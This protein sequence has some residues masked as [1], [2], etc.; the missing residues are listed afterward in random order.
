[1][2][3][4]FFRFFANI[5]DGL[6]LNCSTE[7]VRTVFTQT[8]VMPTYLVAFI[9]SDFNCTQGNPIDTDVPHSVCSTKESAEERALAVEY[10]PRLMQALENMVGLKFKDQGLGKMHQVAL[11]DFS[12]GAMENWGLV[13]YR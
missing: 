5:S 3:R 4:F 8:P 1:M 11:P 9:V 10:G 6:F 13:T 12:A 2:S 7:H